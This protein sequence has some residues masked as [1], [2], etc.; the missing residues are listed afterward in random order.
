MLDDHNIKIPS[1][2]NQKIAEE[3]IVILSVEMKK[4]Q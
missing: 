1:V 4:K 3:I 2:V